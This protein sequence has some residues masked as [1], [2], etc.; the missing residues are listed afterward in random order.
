[1]DQPQLNISSMLYAMY[2]LQQGYVPQRF[3]QYRLGLSF[4]TT[5]IFLLGG[6][7]TVW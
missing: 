2:I 7:L 1:M 3:A 6:S 4:H 5:A